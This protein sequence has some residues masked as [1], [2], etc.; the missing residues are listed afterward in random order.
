MSQIAISYKFI[1]RPRTI[2][3][4]VEDPLKNMNHDP[5]VIIKPMVKL[6]SGEGRNGG[7]YRG[8]GDGEGYEET[9]YIFEN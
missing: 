2:S 1:S 3:A 4:F 6:A 9:D 5:D 7:R 8:K